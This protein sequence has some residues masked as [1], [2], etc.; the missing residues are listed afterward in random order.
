[1]SRTRVAVAVVAGVLVALFGG[2][3]I[4]LRYTE[5]LWYA[6]LGQGARFRNLLADRLLWQGLVFLGATLWYGAHL[7]G[8][9]L[10]IGSVHLPRRIGNLEIAEAVPRRV[11]RGIAASVA[12]ALGLLTAITFHDLSDYVALSRAAVPF[13]VP[14]PVLGRDASFYLA[15]LPLIET[16]HLLAAIAV[17]VA[18]LLVG[19]LYALTGSLV[20]RRRQL[21][22][23]AHARAHLVAVL[24]ALALV[25]AW[26]FQVDAY[27]LVGGG[28]GAG[29]ALSVVDRSLRI[30]ASTTLAAAGLVVAALTALFL[31]WGGGGGL[32][33]IWGTYAALA[34]G[35]RYVAPVVRQAWAGQPDPSVTLALGDLA[36][37]Y[38][39]AGLGVS[40]VRSEALAARSVLDTDSASTLGAAL[41]GLSP[42]STEPSL[43]SAWLGAAAADSGIPRLWTVTTSAYP[44]PEGRPTLQAVAVPETDVLGL[45]RSRDRPGWTATHRGR[46]AWGQPALVLDLP[47]TGSA[48]LAPAAT[49]GP[50][51]FLAHE[52][53]LAVV[54]ED[55]RTRGEGPVGVP[56]RGFVRR[57]LLAWALQTPPLLGNRTSAGDRVLYWRDVPQ[58]LGRLY[59]FASFASPRAVLAAGRLVWVAPG[60]LASDRF[61]LAERVEWQDRSVN[62]L[63]APYVATV[64]AH[65]GAT[66]I[67]LRGQDSAFAARLAR[68]AG[69]APLPAESIP[70]ALRP[71]LGYPASLFSVQAEV[72][73]RHHG[74]PGQASWALARQASGDPGEPGAGPR[75]AAL[76][77]LLALDGSWGLWRLLPLADGG[78]NR[79]LGFVAG[80]ESEVGPMTPRL[81]RLVSADFPTLA[82]AES[83]LNATPA[84]V[85][86]VAAAAG[87]DGA[88][89]R[90]PVVALPAGGTVVY[91]QTIFASPRRLAQ[92]LQ[93]SAITLLLGGR[94]GVGD[95]VAAAVHAL[96]SSEAPAETR[97]RTDSSLAAA[98]AAFLALDS[99]TRAGDWPRFGRAIEALRRALGV[100]VERKR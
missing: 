5:A 83:R 37:R 73:A 95:D 24:A 84:V 16:V 40:G 69:A 93:V 31:R 85:G 97:T 59:P 99:A 48:R 82:A 49:A 39:R 50:V 3:W 29:G 57:L 42:W 55:A 22:V 60:F 11:L 28:G 32:I 89:H 67:Y 86:A 64:D 26:G 75:P 14:E 45:L 4:A 54:G 70:G 77:V 10:S 1:M 87:P 46:L 36:D 66:R 43:L 90:S 72:L 71:H 98:R 65:S 7:F 12:A 27:Q 51:R 6:D 52:G 33:A 88:V 63:R 38:S 21:A 58:R 62:Y 9:Y 80:A 23:T 41:A 30:P 13:G 53:E 96:E 19:G 44:G 76:E 25:V 34:I 8:V 47:S 56:L 79:L 92:P 74:E 17:V 81:L 20:V 78:G 61:P 18:L 35:G 100:A 94:V 15:R 2:R 91:A 68:L